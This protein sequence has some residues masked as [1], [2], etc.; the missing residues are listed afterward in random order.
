MCVCVC[1]SVS[2]REKKA[3]AF[4]SVCS[5]PQRD[6]SVGRRTGAAEETNEGGMK[7]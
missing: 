6:S 5:A 2:V 4:L 3:L 7:R 1:V